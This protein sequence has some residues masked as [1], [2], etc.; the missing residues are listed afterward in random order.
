MKNLKTSVLSALVVCLALMAGAMA[1]ESS[2]EKPKDKA[3]EK[4]AAAPSA[5]AQA[6]SQPTVAMILDRQLT[7]LE[8]DFVPAAEA[9][10]EDK[11]NF[12]PTS[13]EFKTVRTFALE[14]KHV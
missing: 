2:K 9:M 14:I 4:P 7:T 6:A 1:Q 13:G 10:P 11:F 5:N 3:K 12:A 8:K